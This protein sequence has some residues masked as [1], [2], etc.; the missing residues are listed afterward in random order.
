VQLLVEK[1]KNLDFKEA[2]ELAA[3]VQPIK[4]NPQIIDEVS[5][6]LLYKFQFAVAS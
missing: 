6:F 4:V 3:D 2:L 5:R 1:N